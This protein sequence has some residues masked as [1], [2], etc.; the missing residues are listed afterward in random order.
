MT[1]F[2]ELLKKIVGLLY[3]ISTWE[4]LIRGKFWGVMFKSSGKR[5]MIE[6]GCRFANPKSIIMGNKVF[7][8]SAVKILSSHEAG[9]SI[10]DFVSVGP[11]TVMVAC[12]YD[13]A[14]WHKPLNHN[15]KFLFEPIAIGDDVW[16]GA[17]VVILPGVKIGRGAVVGAGAVVT[18]DVPSFAIV[19]GVPA[20]VL[21]Y[22]FDKTTRNKAVKL[23]FKKYLYG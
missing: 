10:G 23:S 2:E 8:N 20:K 16:I 17:N 11:N 4:Y 1:F 19:G 3:S 21:R 7:I 22:R 14:D 12:N 15:T 5:L 9:I 6:R 13:V 18:N